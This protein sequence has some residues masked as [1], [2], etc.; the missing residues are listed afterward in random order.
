MHSA[1]KKTN[2]HASEVCKK[3]NIS[4]TVIAHDVTTVA[5]LEENEM[6]QGKQ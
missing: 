4:T 1:E 3:I 5:N 2:K 6:D